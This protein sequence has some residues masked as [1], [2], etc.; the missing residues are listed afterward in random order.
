VFVNTLYEC[1]EDFK[2][3]ITEH[4]LYTSVT[5][6]CKHELITYMDSFLATNLHL[7]SLKQYVYQLQAETVPPL[8]YHITVLYIS[9]TINPLC[10]HFNDIL[11]GILQ[12]IY[13]LTHLHVDHIV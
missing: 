3:L 7:F 8:L 1:T 13:G 2:L 6:Y 4:Y 9:K 11:D 10:H 12:S 5:D